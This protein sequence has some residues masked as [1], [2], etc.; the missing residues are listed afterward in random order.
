MKPMKSQIWIFMETK[1]SQ[2]T[3]ILQR[4]FFHILFVL[5]ACLCKSFQFAS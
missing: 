2:V 3:Y 4:F 1:I 5:F